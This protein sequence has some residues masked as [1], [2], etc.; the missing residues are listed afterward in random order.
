MP[1]KGWRG[2]YKKGEKHV[3]V[4]ARKGKGEDKGVKG[5]RKTSG[6]DKTHSEG[7]AAVRGVRR[8]RGARAVLSAQGR[9][10]RRAPVPEVQ[11]RDATKQRRDSGVALK[12]KL[13]MWC[14]RKFPVDPTVSGTTT[15]N[16]CGEN[17]AADSMTAR[18][19]GLWVELRRSAI[20]Y[21][22]AAREARMEAARAS[23]TPRSGGGRR[24]PTPPEGGEND[25]E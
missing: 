2:S 1:P 3:E 24:K 7:A 13:C 16:F 12:S 10:K 18:D 9:A 4:K 14:E 5:S 8:G 23:R 17:C 6:S 19:Q 22:K 11:D 21:R 15:H 20:G 25:T